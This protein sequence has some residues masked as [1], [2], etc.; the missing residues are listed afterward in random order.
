MNT[1]FCLENMK[2][3]PLERPR[4]RREKIIK[5]NIKEIACVVVDL[6]QISVWWWAY[7]STVKNLQVPYKVGNFLTS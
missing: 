1:S 4:H 2:K 7:V 5:M 6:A 3:R